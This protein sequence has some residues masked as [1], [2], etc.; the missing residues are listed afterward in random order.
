[1]PSVFTH[2]VNSECAPLDELGA[3]MAPFFFDAF[4]LRPDPPFA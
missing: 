3:E 1:M 4:P 2:R